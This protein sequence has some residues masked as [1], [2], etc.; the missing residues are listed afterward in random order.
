MLKIKIRPDLGR[1]VESPL[2]EISIVG[3]NSL[4][5]QLQRGLNGSIIFKDVVGFLRP[6]DLSAD[7]VPA[8]TTRMAYALR[9]SQESFAA[10]QIKIAALQIRIE[11][12][13]FQRNRGLPS[14]HLQHR[15]PVQPA[16]ARSQIVLHAQTP[17]QLPFLDDE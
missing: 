3:M 17:Y 16:G 6:V 7:N 12:G 9:L 2:H 1:S 4:K 10:L 8:E 11:A 15:D 5:Y 14:Q 13:I